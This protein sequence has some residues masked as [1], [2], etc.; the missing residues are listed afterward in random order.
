MAIGGTLMLLVKYQ[1]I[2]LPF[3]SPGRDKYYYAPVE[4]QAETQANNS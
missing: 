4:S 1:V 3:L 2:R